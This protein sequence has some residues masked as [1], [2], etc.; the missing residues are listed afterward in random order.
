MRTWVYSWKTPDG[1]RHEG[2]MSAPDKDS[3][4]SELRSR[5]IRAI[6]VT[7]RIAPV[8]RRGFSGLRKRDWTLAA[9]VVLALVGAALWFLR[10]EG[11]AE[12]QVP[13]RRPAGRRA[14]ES[15]VVEVRLGDRVATAR[16]RHQFELPADHPTNL[17]KH[18]SEAYLAR[19]ARPGCALGAAGAKAPAGFADD[20]RDAIEDPIVISADDPKPVA[21]LK[22]VVVGIKDEAA[23]SLGG[24]RSAEGF[25]EYLVER[26]RMEAAWRESMVRKFREGKVAR[27]EANRQ[28]SAMALPSISDDQNSVKDS[29]VGG[30]SK[31]EGSGRTKVE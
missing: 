15:Q 7:E 23:L 29:R 6:K 11:P 30:R 12:T 19:F 14:I 3:V 21:E 4:Y 9:V 1:L 2:E 28:L 31:V 24:G 8:V 22:R 26:Q 25:A 18:V 10:D 5:G 16:P 27:E 17:F 13:D 20:L